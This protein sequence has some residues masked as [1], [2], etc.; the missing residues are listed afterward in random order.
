MKKVLSLFLILAAMGVAAQVPQWISA[1]DSLR[2]EEN[3]WIEF[4]KNFSL[5]KKPAEAEVKIA[6][7]SKYWLWINDS[8]AVFEGSL[9][10]GPNPT[11]GYYD[12]VDIAPLPQER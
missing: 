9:K 7:D 3:T 11:D 12:V 8:M 1:D 4:Q 10:R 5:K 6:A 2:N